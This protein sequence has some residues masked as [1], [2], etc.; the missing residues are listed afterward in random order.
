MSRRS[1]RHKKSGS[2]VRM[3]NASIAKPCIVAPNG[4][5]IEFPYSV[6]WSKDFLIEKA[7]LLSNPRTRIGVLLKG[8]LKR[9]GKKTRYRILFVN[10]ANLDDVWLVQ[11]HGPGLRVREK[12]SKRGLNIGLIKQLVNNEIKQIEEIIRSMAY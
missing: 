7:A 1:H 4:D 3:F 6:Q 2:G 10:S 8:P 9:R 12:S 11:K 5:I